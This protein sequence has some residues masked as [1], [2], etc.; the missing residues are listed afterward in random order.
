MKKTG[1]VLL[2]LLVLVVSTALIYPTISW[3]FFTSGDIKSLA[4][5]SNTSI[6]DYSMRE[7][8]KIVNELKEIALRSRTEEI[9]GEYRYL[10]RGSCYDVL[11]SYES[12][13]D[14]QNA[15]E[16]HIRG[17]IFRVKNLSSR[18][19]KLGL[20][21]RGGMSVVLEADRDAY[22]SMHEGT[23][24]TDQEVSSLVLQDME[25]LSS[26]VDQ[27]G[28][29]EPEIRA[30]GTDQIVLELPGESDPERVDS[31]LRG[32]GALSFHL[33]DSALSE[34]VTSYFRANPDGI[35][36]EDGNIVTPSFVPDGMKV[37]GI[38]EEDEYGLDRLT[39]Y[40][41]ID[42]SVVIDGTHL[43]TARSDNSQRDGR[44]VVTFRFDDEGGDIFYSFTSRH[45]ESSLALVLDDMVKSVA[46]INSAISNS[47]ELSG[48]FTREEADSIAVVLR[49]ASLPMPLHVVSE[50][51]VGASLGDDA[52]RTALY[53]IFFG[54]FLVLIF[55]V[56]FYGP[57]GII[58]DIA[59]LLNFYMML[60]VLSALSFTLT[61]TSI[62]GLVLTLGMAIDANVIIYERMKEEKRNGLLPFEV[63]KKGFAGAFWTIMD[64][65]ITTI[66][67]ALVLS[68]FGS[69]S[70]KGFA[71]TL[72][73]GVTCSLFTA[74]FVSHLIFDFFV[75]EN[76]F[77]GVA[78]SWRR[79]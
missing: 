68:V 38:Y 24:L 22:S 1:R 7:S 63:V 25:I 16:S 74:L 65:N 76:S 39:G 58:A 36:D 5:S 51:T 3:Y 55:M 9:P 75:S 27:F 48:G 37:L 77:R 57:A 19:L 71:N 20:D 29:S 47:V 50:Q 21:L 69:S 12:E 54:L 44:P 52:V 31:L 61:L 6:R 49:S 73:I 23:Q 40:A 42:E 30:Q 79:K 4:L 2:V 8:L 45:I 62:A 17:E 78:L 18:A 67:A 70:V 43:E 60:S 56:I 59:L 64:S 41:V 66:I 10:G 35:Y 72:A 53:A 14:L 32:R 11:S 28:V 34:R 15:I 33:A 46:T 13:L 26:R